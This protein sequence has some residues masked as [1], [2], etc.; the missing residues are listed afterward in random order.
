MKLTR[1]RI[2]WAPQAVVIL[3]FLIAYKHPYLKYTFTSPSEPYQNNLLHVLCCAAF[4]YLAVRAYVDKKYDWAWGFAVT[5]IIY[6]PISPLDF[7][8]RL[9][10]SV[11]LVTI[12]LAV[13]SIKALSRPR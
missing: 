13:V 6:N 10:D 3:M 9:W 4:A 7:T 1:Y 2:I 11:Y 8:C 5:A 12:G